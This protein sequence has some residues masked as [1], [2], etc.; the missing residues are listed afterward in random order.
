MARFTIGLDYGT[1]SVRA[2]LVNLESGAEVAAYVF[3]YPSG[4]AG[5]LLDDSDVNLARQ[6]PQDYVDGFFATITGVLKE[7]G[8]S[9]DDVIGLGVDTTGSSPLPVDQ[10][11]VPLAFHLDF[12]DNLNAQCWLWKDHTSFAEAA[13]ITAL[14]E[15]LNRPFLAKCGGTYSS[16]WFWS[17]LLHCAR[18]APD[19]FD[20]THSWVECCDYVCAVA[21]GVT[22]PAQIKR[23][24]CAAGHKAMF[25]PDWDG[26]P[27]TE[28]LANLDPRLADLRPRLYDTAYASDEVF[29]TIS[30]EVAAKTGLNPACIVA[31]SAF[32][33]HHGAVGAGIKPGTLVK[34]MGTST[35]DC[36]VGDSNTPD[37]PGVCGVVNGSVLPGM[38]GIEA[39]QSAVGDIFNSFVKEFAPQ[40]HEVLTA[41]AMQL[42]P[43]ESGLVALDWHNGNRTVL[44]NPR[45]TGTIIGQTLYTTAAETY[46]AL[47][48]ATAF[49]ALTIIR[50]IEEY[51]VVIDEVVNCGGIA[52]KSP[53]IMQIYGDVCN[54]PMKIS[55][56]AQTPALGAALFAAVAAEE[57]A[58][59]AEAQAKLTGVKETI[60]TPIPA[61]VAVYAEIYKI[62]LDLH[63][64]FGGVRAVDL[65]K[66]MEKLMAL[67]DKVRVK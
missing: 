50:R 60:Y 66:T 32:D 14:A 43:G 45:L 19:V 21:C 9:G 55:R 22:D 39:G 30:A 61:N 20:A 12:K 63:D 40:G 1:N 2:L 34:I 13:E 65:S 7:A 27:D 38:L 31:V 18:V 52:E 23:S 42:K 10:N 41:L 48:E 67:R 6:N 16:E 35:C 62:Y 47:V 17:K 37:I 56:S 33:A 54:K 24:V 11:C 5:I 57:F 53:F 8:V 25:S 4:N 64:A 58:N 46:R 36:M 51:G 15:S 28:F 26:L 59:V 44:V 49:G 29:G 3:E